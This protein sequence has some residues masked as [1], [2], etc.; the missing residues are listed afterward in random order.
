VEVQHLR[1]KRIRRLWRAEVVPRAACVSRVVEFAGAGDEVSTVGGEG[2]VVERK[3]GFVGK[4]LIPRIAFV[5]RLPDGRVVKQSKDGRRL[6]EI[7]VLC[8]QRWEF[9]LSFTPYQH[10]PSSQ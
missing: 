10:L 3:E 8:N 1:A 4:Q 2:M 7:R 6:L 9:E 5:A